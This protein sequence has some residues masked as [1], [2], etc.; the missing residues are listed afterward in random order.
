MCFDPN[1]LNPLANNNPFQ[2]INNRNTAQQQQPQQPQLPAGLTQQQMAQL[3]ARQAAPATQPAQLQQNIFAMLQQQQQMQQG[4]QHP[5]QNAVGGGAGHQPKPAPA[6]FNL[7]NLGLLGSPQ[8]GQLPAQQQPSQQQQP[9]QQQPQFSLQAIQDA[10]SKGQIV[11]SISDPT[12][13]D[14]VA[15]QV[16]F[17]FNTRH[18]SNTT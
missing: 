9:P 7:N 2:F 5:H 16:G 1:A 11:R 13:R 6:Q 10:L 4:Q 12:F 18:T 14:H 8:M 17:S 3:F 15:D